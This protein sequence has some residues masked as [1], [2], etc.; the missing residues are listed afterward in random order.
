MGGIMRILVIAPHADDGEIG[1]GGTLA[2]YADMG[3]TIFYATFASIDPTLTELKNAL[4]ILGIP[5]HHIIY[6]P[7][8]IREF[9]YSRQA[10]LDEL[11]TMKYCCAPDLVFI[12]SFNDTHQDHKVITDESFR[13]FKDV[14][15]LGYEIPWNNLTFTTNRFIELTEDHL[16][17]KFNAMFMHKSQHSRRYVTEDFVVSLA[18]V[19]GIQVGLQYTEAFESIRWIEKL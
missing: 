8:K 6:S 3:H 16:K 7:T 9:G 10:I 14:S 19:R 4:E 1:C 2:K 18:K 15:V 12:P 17:R 5:E 13:A 11:I